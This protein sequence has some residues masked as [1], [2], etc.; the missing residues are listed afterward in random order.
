MSANDKEAEQGVLFPLL[1]AEIYDKPLRDVRKQVLERAGAGVV[2][3]CCDR[4][5]KIYRRNLNSGMAH[6]LLR[7]YRFF[8]QH[9]EQ[10]WLHVSHFLRE[11]KIQRAD[12]AK[13][14]HWELLERRSGS[15]TDGSKRNGFYRLTEKGRAFC[16]MQIRVPKYVF[17]QNNKTLGYSDGKYVGVP[18]TVNIQEAMGDRFDY[19]EVMSWTF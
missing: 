19:R 14:C 5:L 15:R 10:G 13:L 11:H 17:L 3:P 6:V 7:V 2:C 4:F 1:D 18:V 12:E 16:E 9:K 8:Q